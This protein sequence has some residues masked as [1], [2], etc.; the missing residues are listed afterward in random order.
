VTGAPTSS[1][2]ASRPDRASGRGRLV[3]A[4]VG[5][6]T[7]AASGLLLQ[8]VAARELGAAGLA[9]FSVGYGA[10][11]LATSVNSGLVGDS[12]TVLD[13]HRHGV[14]AALHVLALGVAVVA[15]LVGGVAAALAGWGGVAAGLWVGLAALAFVLEDVLRRLLMAAGR[16]W[17]LPAVDLGGAA[18]SL[19]VVVALAPG[20]VGLVDLFAALAVGQTTSVVVALVLLPRGER[21]GG[22]WRGGD[23][24]PVVAF[25]AWRAAGQ[26]VRPGTLTLVRVVVIGAAGAAAYGPVEAARVLTA[27]TLVLVAGVGSFLL[28]W[29]AAARDRP[30]QELLRRADRAAVAAAGATALVVVGTVA[31]LPWLGP[32][33]SG[34]EYAVPLVAVLGWGLYAVTGAVL[35]PYAGLASVHRAQ[36]AVLGWRVVELTALLGVAAVVLVHP[37]AAAAAPAVLAAGPLLAAVGVRWRVLVPRVRTARV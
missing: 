32:L 36:R 12:L 21:P 2:T 15:G 9:A 22:P 17:R 4:L 13:R 18:V 7:L 28:P 11:V 33:L 20:G 30:Q 27:P 35:L 8:V 14:R 6:G 19:A 24:R 37:G 29:F 23:L 1:R 31:L 5:Q 3:G 25:G 26:A 34:G 16:Y 10:I